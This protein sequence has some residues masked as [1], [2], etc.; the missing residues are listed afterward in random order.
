MICDCVFHYS[1]AKKNHQIEESEEITKSDEEQIKNSSGEE[2]IEIISRQNVKVLVHKIQQEL[3]S[4]SE[5][6]SMNLKVE[7]ETEFCQSI[8]ELDEIQNI[9]QHGRGHCQVTFLL[10]WH[11]ICRFSVAI[12]YSPISFLMLRQSFFLLPFLYPFAQKVSFSFFTQS[13]F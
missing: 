5:D 8:C 13:S 10:L 7:G 2:D 6:Y 1:C 3:Q 9:C 12:F 11:I 4:G